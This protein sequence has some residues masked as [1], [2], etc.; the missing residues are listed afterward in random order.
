M[1]RV[2]EKRK[3]LLRRKLADL[4]P[5]LVLYMRSKDP[6]QIAREI[7]PGPDGRR[8]SVKWVSRRIRVIMRW[9]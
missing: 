9:L 3:A 4:I 7:P 5:V 8:R 2:A 6:K 1:A